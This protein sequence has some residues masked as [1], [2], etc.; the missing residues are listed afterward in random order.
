MMKSL[1]LALGVA[2]LVASVA[3]LAG[4]SADTGLLLKSDGSAVLSA[5][6]ELPEVV[7]QRLRSLAGAAEDGGSF[8][9]V[10]AVTLMML[11]RGFSVQESRS[12]SPRSYVGVFSIED[13]EF[14]LD[15]DPD[16]AAAELFRVVSGPGWRELRVT[17]DRSNA[18]DLVKMFPGVDMQLL[19]SLSPP[20]LF[21][22]PI[23]RSDYHSMLAALL[24]RAA[25]V[26]IDGG[27]FNLTI[28]TPGRII[29]ATGGAIQADRRGLV[30]SLPV[31]DA[32][33]LE[34]AVHIRIR[35]QE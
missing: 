25:I 35:W 28:Q 3:G 27:R 18:Q 21:D 33:V 17:I 26:A 29:D 14:F 30:F 31:L 8:F 34:Q 9:D 2:L 32:M 22:L 15:N 24:G 13:F 10:Q 4:C 6:F 19:E 23:S 11:T 12:P 16:I 5:Q 7:E 20:A 1:K